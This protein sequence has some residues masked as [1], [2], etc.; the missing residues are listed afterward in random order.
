MPFSRRALLAAA[1]ASLLAAPALAQALTPIRFTL[2]WRF[3]GVH[4]WFYLARERGWFREAG[5][6]VTID[7]G[8]GSTATV[9]RIMAGAYDAGFGD[10]NAIIQQAANRPGEAPVMVYQ[11]YNTPPFALIAKASGPIRTVADMAGKR[12]GGS[13]GSTTMQL[14]PL[15]ARLNGIDLPRNPIVSIAP[16]LQ[17]PMLLR[18]QF[19]LGAV[20]TVTAH[21]NFRALGLD[22]DKDLRWFLFSD[23]GIDL[24]S[25]GTMVSQRLLRDNPNGVRGMVAA[26]NR[27]MLEIGANPPLAAEVMRRVD[28]TINAPMEIGRVEFAWRT[29]IATPEGRRLGAGDLD[30]A[31]L[32]RAIAQAVEVFGLPRTPA[33]GDVF[34]RDFLPPRAAREFGPVT[35]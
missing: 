10:Q 22:P 4:A 11:M 15:F 32:T 35:G 26:I 5:L 1:P 30:D 28:A 18:D 6:D 27:A 8:E 21:T 23:F 34:R 24:Y 16:A 17:E 25:N 29:L 14:L 7:Q 2:D 31:R 19:D 13:P 3:Q 33:N 20:F 12:I 9:T